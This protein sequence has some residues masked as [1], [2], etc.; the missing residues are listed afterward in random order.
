MG[1]SSFLNDFSQ[2]TQFRFILQHF[3]LSYEDYRIYTG[4]QGYADFI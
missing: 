2:F 3:Q 4:S 1:K